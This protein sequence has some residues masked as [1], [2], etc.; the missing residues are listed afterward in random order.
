MRLEPRL[1]SITRCA[2]CHDVLVAAGAWQCV[3]CGTVLHAECR[4]EVRR[5]PT[6]GCREGVPGQRTWWPLCVAGV[7]IVL[8]LAAGLMLVRDLS[9]VAEGH[10]FDASER[11]ERPDPDPRMGLRT[12]PVTERAPSFDALVARGCE[13][14]RTGDHQAAIAT[15]TSAIVLDATASNA[16]YAFANR[17]VAHAALGHGE[18]AL[19][20]AEEAIRIDPAR[21]EAIAYRGYAHHI[22]HEDETALADYQRALAGLDQ[23]TELAIWCRDALR[24][25]EATHRH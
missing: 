2:L 8:V 3:A 25:V 1:H 16:W 17:S 20:D 4:A 5:C 7:G 22:L 13:L 18:R 15:L 23:K 24:E 14:S 21:A 10:S 12:V 6:L 11:L 9:T 19:L